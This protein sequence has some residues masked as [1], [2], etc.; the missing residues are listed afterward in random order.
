[1]SRI[2]DLITELAPEGV[3]FKA[4]GDIA[5][6]VR[7]NG[8]PKTDLTTEGIGAIHY[9]QIYTYYGVWTD[10]TLSFVTPETARRLAVADPGD[11]I[12]TNT[13]ENLED[14]G[15]A[16][17]WLGAEPIVTGGH[18]TIVKHRED[19]K[20]LSY[21]L[22]S[23]SFFAQKRVLATG[24]KV[25]DVSA[26]Q[27]AKVRVPVP[28]IEVQ[29]EIVRVLDSLASLEQEIVADLE[30]E[31]QARRE[32]YAYYRD[33]Q[34]AAE[35]LSGVKLLPLSEL[36]QF[37]RG[38]RFTK[39]DV[40]EDGIPSIHYGEIYTTYGIATASAVSQVRRDLGP[41]LRYA[42]PGDVVIAA[43]GETVEDVGKGVAWL[44]TTEVAIHDDCFLYRSPSLD[45]KY[46]S[47]YLRTTNLIRAKDKYVS[48][49]KV[50]RMSSDGLGRLEIPVLP[51]EEQRRV[52]A[53]LDKY[54]ALLDDLATS[55]PAEIAARRKQY[56]YYRD[57][58]LTFKELSA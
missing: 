1:M 37:V 57:R 13:S 9:G 46:V 31:L 42:K 32:Q 11:I 15:K 12:I 29:R 48:R 38:R 55:I 35:D 44:G 49:A 21:W 54:G 30:A 27:L 40:V 4:L 25:V 19:P 7:G 10:D 2:D 33:A 45:P 16:V 51:I 34:F 22:Q 18:A 50:K 23:A 17:A 20:F 39:S 5:V 14:V 8:M 24:T 26:K 41:R 53:V 56:E 52:V 6:F 3:P 28:P 47:Y 36:G 58:L 43:V